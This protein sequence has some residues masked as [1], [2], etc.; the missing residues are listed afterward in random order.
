MRRVIVICLA[1]ACT[2][3]SELVKT[4]A[5]DPGPN[6]AYGGVAV[7]TGTD[8][9]GDGKLE[10]WEV[11]KT[12]YVCN[13]APGGDALVDLTPEPVGPNCAYGDTA[14]RTGIDQNHNNMLDPNEIQQ[15]LYVCNGPNG[16]SQ[17]VTTQP[18]PAGSNCP[19][20]GI[21]ILVGTDTNGDGILSSNE[22]TS[23]S[24]VCNGGS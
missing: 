2:P 11:D 17:L 22:V 10:D 15:T 5:E 14:I 18:E 19:F 21:E 20:G 12:M 13:G 23:T 1:A 3:K 6:C 4:V 16:T 8:D 7:E 9:N 24:Y